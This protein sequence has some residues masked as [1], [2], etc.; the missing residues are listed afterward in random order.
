MSAAEIVM[1]PAG[2]GKYR[3]MVG[4]MAIT[5]P[6]RQPLLDGARTLPAL[7]YAP[8][9]RIVARHAGSDIIA[10]RGVLGELARGTV[11]ESDARGLQKRLW[12]PRPSEGGSP[13]TAADDAAGQISPAALGNAA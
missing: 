5:R 13:E 12:R 11:E 1:V 10:L 6:T 4:S 7:G 9:T 2:P 8:E 3:A